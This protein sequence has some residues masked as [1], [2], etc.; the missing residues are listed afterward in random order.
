MANA[1][2]RIIIAEVPTLAIDVVRSKSKQ[3]IYRMQQRCTGF[4]AKATSFT[5]ELQ[6]TGGDSP[7]QHSTAR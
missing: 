6:W 3:G 2:R 4:S 1:L 5:A 7:E